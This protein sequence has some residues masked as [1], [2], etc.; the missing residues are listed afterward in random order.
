[1][2]TVQLGKPQWWPLEQFVIRTWNAEVTPLTPFH[3]AK[4]CS[5]FMFMGCSES[6]ART[7][8]LYKE[9]DTRKYLNLTADS[10]PHAFVP[11]YG[12]RPITVEQ[13]LSHIGET[14]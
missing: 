4:F 7:Y 10:Q 9:I 12:Y 11:G 2:S 13:A 8:Y 14:F 1:M 6:S 5:Q 3:V